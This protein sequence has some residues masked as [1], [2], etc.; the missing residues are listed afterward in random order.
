MQHNP[1]SLLDT[2]NTQFPIG[3]IP[4]SGTEELTKKIEKYLFKWFYEEHPESVDAELARDTMICSAKCPRFYT[5]DA[6]GIINQSVRGYDLY[7]ICD[8]GNY[9]S[10]YKMF[11]QTCF[12]SPDDHFADLKRIILAVG[13]KAS[14]ITVIT[15]M[16][17]G[18]RQHRRSGRE[19]LDAA[20]ALTELQSMGVSGV[21]TFDAHDPRVQNA[22]PL[23]G[24]DNARPSYQML[25]ALLRRFDDIKIDPEHLMIVSPD[26][27]AMDRNIF[28]ASVLG[29]QLGMFY[30]RRDYSTVVD[31]RNPIVEHT[32]IGEDVK[33]KDILVADD[34][35]ASGDSALSLMEDL[36]ERGCGRIFMVP[37]YGLFTSGL[38]R[39]DKAYE[40][41]LFDAII[42]TNLTYQSPELLSREWYISADC[43]KYI[44]YFIYTMHH[45]RSINTVLEPQ[46]KIKELVNDYNSKTGRFAK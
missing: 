43:S 23:M 18:G 42:S 8:V 46:Q 37:S 9:M 27:G 36:K 4:M 41:G 31:G 7:L 11:G 12:M 1:V 28:Y 26:E 5:G 39:F 21:I 19:S 16:L 32:Y 40:K 6:K 10:T 3:L 13:G 17:Y 25:K 35:L 30:K 45:N 24:F 20:Q 44:A 14:R 15:P 33:G 29:V 38:E 2:Q 22:V 34:I